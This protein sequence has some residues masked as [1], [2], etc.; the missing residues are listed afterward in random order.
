[1]GDFVTLYTD[2][3]YNHQAKVATVAYKARSVYGWLHGNLRQEQIP[4]ICYAEMYAILFGIEEVNRQWHDKPLIG[5]F[6]NSDNL[7]VVQCFWSFR[8]YKVPRLCE[9]LKPKI[10]LAAG[11]RWIR[12][13]HVKAHTSG[14]DVRSWMNREV[15]RMTRIGR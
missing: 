15:D 4:S 11:D 2:A 13:K 1:M 9:E 8:Q 5:Y 10:H 7:S 6:V 12:T 14:Q 3:S